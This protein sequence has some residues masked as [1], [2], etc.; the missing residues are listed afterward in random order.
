MINSPLFA[1]SGRAQLATSVAGDGHALVFL[2]AG[3]AD[4][5]MWAGQMAAFAS[6]HRVAAYDRRGFGETLYEA[7]PHS[8]LDDLDAV[9]RATT[10]GPV[11]LVGCSQGGRVAIDFALTR[12]ERVQ[13]LVLVAPAVTGA[14]DPGELPPAVQ[15]LATQIEEA[16][17]AEDVERLNALE[18][19]AWLDGPLSVEGRVGGAV[20]ALFLDMNGRALRSPPAGNE[21]SATN[22]YARLGEIPHETLVV[23]GAL[24]F[25]HINARSRHL[26]SVM[27]KARLVEMAGVAHLPNLERPEEFNALLRAFLREAV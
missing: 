7:E 11:T 17:A 27:P 14:P 5:R 20:R 23:S 19:H 18:A 15:R 12:P 24:D 6:S 13:R 21:T 25:P 3:V 22:A 26:A 2:H 9:L 8:Y 16:E 1:C 4:R 10:E